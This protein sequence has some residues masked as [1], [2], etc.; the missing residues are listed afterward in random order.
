MTDNLI[1]RLRAVVV[2]ATYDV[3]YQAAD[4]IE[5]LERELAEERRSREVAAAK[6]WEF[7]ERIK[8]LE[9][10]LLEISNAVGDPSAYWIARTVLEKKNAD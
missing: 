6:A 2:F 1:G 4:R 5:E 8:E 10:A 7:A 9:A 3:C